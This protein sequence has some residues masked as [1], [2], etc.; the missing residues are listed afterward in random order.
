MRWLGPVSLALC[1]VS[2][3]ALTSQPLYAALLYGQLAF[4]AMALAA[5]G[6]ARDDRALRAGAPQ[7][8]LPARERGGGPG[9]A[10]VAGGRPTGALGA[11]AEA[12]VSAAG[13]PDRGPIRVLHLRDS[14]WV[15]G[16]GRTILETATRIDRSRIDYHVGAFVSNPGEPHPL[17]EALQQR[18]LPVHRDR[19]SGRGRRRHGEQG[20]RP[21][22]P[23]E[24]RH[25]A[26]LRVPLERAGAALPTQRPIKLVSTAHG[27]IANDLRGQVYMLADRVL[28]RRFDRVILVSH[29]MRRRLPAWWV[30]DSQVQRAAQCP[31]D[32]VLRPRPDSGTTRPDPAKD[33]RVLN[34][35]RLSPEK[36]QALLLQAVASLV[37]E[38]PGLRMAFA[39][40]GP[41]EDSLRQESKRLCIAER[42][43]F[44]GYVEDM[45]RLYADY[46]LVVQS[47][48]TEGLPNVML[49]PLISGSRWW[50][51]TWAAPRGDPAWRDGLAG[52][53]RSLEAL[54]V[55]IRRYLAEPEAFARM[56]AAGR[57]QIEAEFSLTTR[58]QRQTRFYAEIAG[59]GS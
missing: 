54:A 58:T 18:G 47:S 5:L 20:R 29:A 34:V 51:R 41:L 43:E 12:G 44:L 57:A 40:I 23:A 35:G 10:A 25:P 56:A 45:P 31:D 49:E 8:V 46:D 39:G 22:R 52:G 15:D 24:D 28:L 13:Q 2:A 48:F 50:Q 6:V 59:V 11:D 38:F 1:L 42:V 7:R 9:A 53:P 36:G 32:R 14:P 4:Y 19:G 16:P 17:V 27:W 21:D 33:V 37:P 26:Y 3:F 30:P 55:G